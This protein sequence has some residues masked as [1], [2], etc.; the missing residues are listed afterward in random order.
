VLATEALGRYRVRAV[1]A[2]VRG[3]GEEESIDG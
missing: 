3:S 1:H 2:A